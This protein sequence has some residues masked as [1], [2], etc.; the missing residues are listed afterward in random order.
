LKN[1][2]YVERLA[3]DAQA[4]GRALADGLIQEVRYGKEEEA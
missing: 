1:H 3:A 2:A 4:L